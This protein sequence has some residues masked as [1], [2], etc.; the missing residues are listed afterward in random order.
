VLRNI[1]RVPEDA[2]EGSS[3]TVYL[4]FDEGERVCNMSGYEAV[5]FDFD[6]TLADSFRGIV[7]CANHALQVM[8]LPPTTPDEIRRTVGYSLPESLVRLVG[9]EH[10]AR[11][12][13]YMRLFVEKADEV[14]AHLTYVYEFVPETMEHL[15]ALGLRLG[16]VSTKYRYRI[17]DVL[18]RDGLL[19]PFEVIVGGEDVSEFK[20]DPESLN[21]ALSKLDIPPDA[22]LYVGD[23]VVDA[24]ASMRAGIPFAA[25]LTGTT[26]RDAFSEFESVMILD[27]VRG[28][29]SNL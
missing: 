22:A 24:E 21:L 6:F 7:E 18:G 25:V 17:E 16:I 9:E 2:G 11:G 1:I 4:K 5:I 12:L 23:S 20:P 27:S 8:G 10:S 26:S 15:K 14:M 13:E 19:E 3:I 29:I 28:L